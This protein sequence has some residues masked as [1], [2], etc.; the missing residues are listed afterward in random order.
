MS[1][2]HCF[3]LDF[4]LG[5]VSNP[6][7]P[8]EPPDSL[9]L[10]AAEG[11]LGLGDAAE[12]NEEL[13]RITPGHRAHPDA[14]ELRWQIYAKAEKWEACVQIA[15]AIVTLVPERPFGWVHRSFALHALKRTQEARD[16]LRP[17]VDRFPEE[18]IIR[19]NLACYESQLGNLGRAKDW[20]ERA[21]ELGDTAQ[22]KLAALDD[23]DLAPLWKDITST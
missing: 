22:I 8:L 6:M 23:P 7:K 15:N 19:Y 9:Y 12:A 2:R 17:A 1:G 16:Q 5:L 4:D 20:L 21:F 13:D 11:W 10:S 14:L 18:A 3:P